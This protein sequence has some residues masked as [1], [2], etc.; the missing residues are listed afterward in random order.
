MDTEAFIA[1]MIWQAMPTWAAYVNSDNVLGLDEK[2]TDNSIMWML[3]TLV[4]APQQE[5]TANQ[6]LAI[7]TASLWAHA[8][9]LD[10][11]VDWTYLN[12]AA[13]TQGPL[14]EYGQ[15]NVD[16]IR[17]VA[18]ACDPDGFF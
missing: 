18:A 14:K 1:G 11:S 17:T 7:L 12:Y 16:F 2:L 9:S 13:P 3:H 5:A 15:A 6:Y 8:E 10:L 4:D